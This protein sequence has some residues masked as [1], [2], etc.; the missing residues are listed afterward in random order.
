MS[1]RF[2]VFVLLVTLASSAAAQTCPRDDP[3]GPPV[4]S[5]ARTL[6]G[7]LVWHDDLRGWFGLKTDADVCGVREVQLIADPGDDFGPR[8]KVIEQ[9]METLRT[10]RVRTHGILQIPITGYY[11]AAVYQVLTQ[12]GP[13]GQCTVKAVFPD[14]SDLTPIPGLQRYT[15]SMSFDYGHESP[16]V[17][18]VT[19]HQQELKPWQAYAH[20][21][22]TGG[23]VFYAYC[24]KDFAATQF[25]GTPAAKPWLVDGYVA[26]DPESAAAK[27]VTHIALQYTCQT[28]TNRSE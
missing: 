20:Y 8:W 19:A 24:A 28:E 18:H 21:D 25:H 4:P 17:A 3:N 7:Q 26:M 14:Y 13:V 10:C 16:L 27:H 11:S 1:A 5:N 22:L 6:E 12:I 23:F 2:F 15:V 9:K